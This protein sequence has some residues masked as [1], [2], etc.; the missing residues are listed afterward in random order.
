MSAD[1]PVGLT[2]YIFAI[3]YAAMNAIH[4]AVQALTTTETTLKRLIGEAADRGEYSSI[5]NLARWAS[6]IGAMCAEQTPAT[7]QNETV[8][9]SDLPAPAK[10]VANSK[11]KALRAGGKTKRRSYPVFAKSGDMLV[12]IAWS[13]S[14]KSEY[15]HKSPRAAIKKLADSFARYAK[16]NAV[17]AMDKVL[18]LKG[19]DGSEIP[20]YQV[21]V[22][23]AWLRQIGAVKQNGRQGYTI[24]TAS[25]LSQ[26]IDTAWNALP[27]AIPN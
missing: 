14:S 3:D 24:K 25:E 13:K 16:G 9:N 20:D 11:P 22:S 6:A 5:E 10:S 1:K 21:Y 23:L 17:V 12:K 7:R 27:D 15:Q 2:R 4:Q 18:P 8:P 19:D 26:K